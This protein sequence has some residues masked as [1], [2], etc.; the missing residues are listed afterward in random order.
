MAIAP[1]GIT[2]SLSTERDMVAAFWWKESVVTCMVAMFEHGTSG[3]E[4][5]THAYEDNGKDH[6]DHAT[7]QIL[8][9]DEVADE[10]GRHDFP[11]R[12]DSEPSP[13]ANGRDRATVQSS[14]A[15]FEASLRYGDAASG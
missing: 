12:P 3:P 7:M 1:L 9:G 5:Y 14:A 11:L 13:I 6:A 4:T 2:V 8:D 10:Y 15:G